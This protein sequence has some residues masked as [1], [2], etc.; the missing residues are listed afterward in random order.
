MYCKSPS[1]TRANLHRSQSVY[2]KSNN[3]LHST[4][5]ELPRPGPLVPAQSLYPMRLSHQAHAQNQNLQNQLYGARGVTPGTA[6]DPRE[7]ERP[8]VYGN[9]DSFIMIGKRSY[10][11]ESQ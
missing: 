9:F 8:P 3:A 10:V 7:R 11:I 6:A 1:L 5:R 4:G 2:T